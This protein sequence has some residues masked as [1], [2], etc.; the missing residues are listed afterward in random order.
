M[1]I[2]C[3]SHWSFCTTAKVLI[4]NAITFLRFCC[5]LEPWFF[6][7]CKTRTA[8]LSPLVPRVERS[9][10]LRLKIAAQAILTQSVLFVRIICPRSC[11]CYC[12]RLLTKS[13]LCCYY[14]CFGKCLALFFV[15]FAFWF[16]ALVIE[17]SALKLPQA[18]WRE[19]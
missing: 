4:H 10:A 16:C 9:S 6:Y 2:F 13:I 7:F 19:A 15:C 18:C 14:P 5:I 8:V 11:I 3:C 1:L 12:L 17:G